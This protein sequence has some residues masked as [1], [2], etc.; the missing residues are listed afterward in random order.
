MGKCK[1]IPF[2]QPRPQ[3]K[4]S[5]MERLL[6]KFGIRGS[7]AS[8]NEGTVVRGFGPGAI[9]STRGN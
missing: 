8:K 7:R 5:L 4:L 2:R 9:R 6:L 3:R 1:V